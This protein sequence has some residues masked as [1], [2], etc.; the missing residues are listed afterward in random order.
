[1]RHRNLERMPEVAEASTGLSPTAVPRIQYGALPFRY[2]GE[3]GIEIMLVTSR[4]TRRWIVP[5]GWPIA[6]LTPA[7]S[8][9]REA[10]EEAGVVGRVS[11]SPLGT[12]TYEKQTREGKLNK[13]CEVTVFALEVH[14]QLSVWPESDQRDV[15][16]FSKDEA[17]MAV[18]DK[19]LS[20]LID[21]ICLGSK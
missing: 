2:N 7:N 19:G 21:S 10:F 8:A 16:W 6:E 18:S 5:K 4:R 20:P 11:Q 9:A 12:F 17:I 3:D 13:M 15:R 1:M 14:Q